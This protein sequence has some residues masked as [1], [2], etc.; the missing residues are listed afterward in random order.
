[1]TDRSPV[2]DLVEPRKAPR[3]E[4]GV[5]PSVKAPETL[6]S[7]LRKKRHWVFAATSVGLLVGLLWEP[8]KPALY[9]SEATFLV[10]HPIELERSTE[11]IDQRNIQDPGIQAAYLCT[12]SDLIARLGV[13]FHKGDEPDR[14]HFL[15]ELIERIEARPIEQGVVQVFLSDAEGERALEMTTALIEE[16]GGLFR[17][18]Q[19][20]RLTRKA[21]GLERVAK[22]T[23]VAYAHH[24]TEGKS[25]LEEMI[26]LLSASHTGTNGEEE[27]RTM[28]SNILNAISAAR[29]SEQTLVTSLYQKSALSDLL[30][31]NSSE[32]IIVLKKPKLTSQPNVLSRTVL[33]CLLFALSAALLSLT[34]LFLWFNHSHEL[35]EALA[36]VRP[37]T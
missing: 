28:E 14:N 7:W 33:P 32:D 20:S 2:I 1:M 5:E 37:G 30:L 24:A 6:G 9:R 26:R 8:L 23:A 34:F 18:L 35:R 25:K 13:R 21:E 3:R 10:T 31:H 12:S 15:G 29:S 17:E 16:L 11:I 19:H 36:S 4:Q 27:K 22:N